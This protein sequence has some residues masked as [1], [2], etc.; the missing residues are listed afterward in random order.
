MKCPICKCNMLDQD[1]YYIC[2]DDGMINKMRLPNEMLVG[3][4]WWEY[5]RMLMAHYDKLASKLKGEKT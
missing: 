1:G 3:D 2:P 4:N 5:K